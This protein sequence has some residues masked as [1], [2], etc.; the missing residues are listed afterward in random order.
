VGHHVQQIANGE[1]TSDA[2]DL[3][4]LSPLVRTQLRDVFHALGA[5]QRR[6]GP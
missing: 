4:A 6:H 2:L 3:A 5:I 1:P